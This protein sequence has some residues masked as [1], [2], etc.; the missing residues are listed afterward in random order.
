MAVSVTASII[1]GTTQFHFEISFIQMNY[2]KS[3]VTICMA[4]TVTRGPLSCGHLLLFS[5]ISD[6]LS[7]TPSIGGVWCLIE[8]VIEWGQVGDRRR[9]CAPHLSV[10]WQLRTCFRPW[11]RQRTRAR[12]FSNSPAVDGSRSTPFRTASPVGPSSTFC[13]MNWPPSSEA[14][15]RF[16]QFVMTDTGREFETFEQVRGC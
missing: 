3:H 1:P 9:Q 4:T 13:A 14:S 12:T 5:L 15:L 10:C 2:I 6:R 16:V 8:F 11:T 7:S